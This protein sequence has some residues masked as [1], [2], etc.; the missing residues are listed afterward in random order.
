MRCKIDASLGWHA[1]CTTAREE[2]LMF[3]A[4]IITA[5]VIGLVFSLLFS[6]L[7]RER[8]GAP[9]F[10]LAFMLFFLFAWSGGLWLQPWGPALFGVYWLPSAVVTLLIFLLIASFAQRAP[11]TRREAREQIEARRTV[12][13]AF[14]FIFWIVV[15]ALAVSVVIGYLV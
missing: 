7:F 3:F 1:A 2:D 12:L 4:E 6:L 15:A 8:E 5:L 14:G 13:A 9:G 10:I 11:R